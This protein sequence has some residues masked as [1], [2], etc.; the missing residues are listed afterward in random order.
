MNRQ[1]LI[2]IY[3]T[4]LAL[5]LLQLGKAVIWLF[6]WNFFWGRKFFKKERFLICKRFL[7]MEHICLIPLKYWCHNFWK[8]K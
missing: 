6:F 3:Y 4:Y 7:G 8:E 5:N 2:S 1:F